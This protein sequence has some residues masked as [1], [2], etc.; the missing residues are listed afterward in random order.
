MPSGKL[1]AITAALLITTAVARA[2]VEINSKPTSN[3]S[4]DAGVCT[5][6]AQ[7][8]VLNV[9]D[10]A[11]MLAS[12]DV[13]VKTGLMA[14]DI[15]IDQPLTWS[16][17]SRLTLDAQQSVT[18][19]KQVTVAG[20]GALTVIT[21]DTGQP[22]AKNKTGEFIIVPERGRVQFWDK[23][24]NLV[25]DGQSYTLVYDIKT[26]AADIAANPSGLYALAKP[27]D[28]SGDGVYTLSPVNTEF[29]GT[30]SG[31]GN[32]ISNITIHMT[33]GANRYGLFAIVGQNGTVADV[34]LTNV[35]IEGT[36]LG[37]GSIAEL[38][39]GLVKR[40]GATGEI[41][42][43]SGAGG[44][45]A[46]NEGSIT[47]SYARVRL[48]INGSTVI[49]AGGLVGYN[50]DEISGSYTGGSIAARNN[51]QVK[52][53]GLVGENARGITNSYTVTTLADGRNN[54]DSSFGG[55][56]GA[57][58]NGG[59]LSATYAAGLFKI[60]QN[61]RTFR[62]G[63]VGSDNAEA[64]SISLS[65]WDLDMGISDPSQGAGSVANDPGITGLTTQQF[66]SGLPAGFDARVWAEDPKINNGFP[67]LRT[68]R[69]K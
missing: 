14:K 31:L 34:H 63:L 44:L 49:P 3:M 64:G 60:K 37:A 36:G 53:G 61:Q 1:T 26:L 15:D 38:N 57:N 56:I 65:Y 47:N 21:N 66:Q 22:H 2:D 16:S 6:T 9:S 25:I 54:L 28:A 27:Y 40:S 19:K 11:T 12:G 52:I 33:G 23:G 59:T 39:D 51:G 43:T 5:A 10:L 13:A 48:N 58:D 18:I 20:Q 42:T 24:S 50:G 29:F 68:L 62:G 7:K 41:Q 45:V 4:C 35:S 46:E 8:A 30:F 69:P 55:L 32:D 17:T 67:Y